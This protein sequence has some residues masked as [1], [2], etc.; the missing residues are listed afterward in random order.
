[1]AKDTC[2]YAEFQGTYNDESFVGI[3]NAKKYIN[4]WD[5]WLEIFP[6]EIINWLVNEVIKMSDV[7]AIHYIPTSANGVTYYEAHYTRLP[8]IKRNYKFIEAWGE[9]TRPC[10]KDAYQYIVPHRYQSVPLRKAFTEAICKAYPYL[11]DYK[12]EVYAPSYSASPEL[13]IKLPF[14]YNGEETI[15]TLYC[16]IK[17]FKD[18]N[19]QLIYDRHYS[20]NNDYYKNQPENRNRILE[21]LN[22]EEYKILCK[23][24]MEG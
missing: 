17:A 12:F 19:P 20:Y 15:V 4:N 7:C 24:V 5:K 14:K 21:A 11:N 16:P 6:E 13:Y 1:M 9:W 22:S 3:E 23:K 8:E 18:K 2:I 10:Y